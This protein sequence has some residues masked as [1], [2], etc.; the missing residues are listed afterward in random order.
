MGLI[1]T[2]KRKTSTPGT[3]EVTPGISELATTVLLTGDTGGGDWHG[4]PSVLDLGSGVWLMAYN[5]SGGHV[6]DTNGQI[7]FKMSDDGG[8]TWTDEDTLL[9]ES[10]MTGVPIYPTGSLGST[11]GPASPLLR[12]ASNGNIIV[13]TM[14]LD[15]T[16]FPNHLGGAWQAISDDD[17][18]T[19]GAI[20]QIDFV[21]IAD[22]DNAVIS[23]DGFVYDGAIYASGVIWHPESEKSDVIL[24]TS[25]DN[26]ATWDYV[27]TAIAY[28]D[29]ENAF[30][31]AIEYL[32]NN[33]IIIIT[34]NY[35]D[36]AVTY[37]ITSDDLGVTWGSVAEITNETGAVGR[38]RIYAVDK[39]K[40]ESTW[41]A[42]T[43]YIMVGFEH[44]VRGNSFYRRTCIWISTNR[45]ASWTRPIYLDQMYYDAGYSDIVYDSGSDKFVVVSYRGT[46]VDA[47]D[48]VQYKFKINGLS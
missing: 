27:S 32:G 30:E 10:G 5:T 46:S 7:H 42:G 45:C 39:L 2:I 24:V 34:R 31:P 6:D 37:K 36:Y 18:E 38:P 29:S 25:D 44:Q 4:R 9:D 15:F 47:A 11:N 13:N 16:N 23:E 33:E 1:S 35:E 14:N 26:G 22:D 28:D 3:T 48:L 19:W 8:E 43:N 20:A 40:G 12:L 21:D 17:G 41:W